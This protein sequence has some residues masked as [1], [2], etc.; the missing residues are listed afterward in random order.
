MTCVRVLEFI[1]CN[2]SDG[3]LRLKF[4][5]CLAT[6]VEIVIDTLV[7][8]STIHCERRQPRK[9]RLI[10]GSHLQKVAVTVSPVSICCWVD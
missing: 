8:G 7:K 1:D 6:A 10:H 4:E 5:P 2:V 9:R 3:G